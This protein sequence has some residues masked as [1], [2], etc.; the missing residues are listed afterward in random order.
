MARQIYIGDVLFNAAPYPIE[1]EP[2]VFEKRRAVSGENRESIRITVYATFAE[3][4]AAL[5]ASTT[6][7]VRET[8]D[9]GEATTYDKSDFSVRGDI[10]V[11]HVAD[12][13]DSIVSVYMGEPTA[14]E[15]ACSALDEILIEM[16]EV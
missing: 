12:G 16:L 15:V 1:S 4:V 10:V 7:G 11:H 5:D 8:P 13:D 2:S 6:W 3:V 14:A 9:G